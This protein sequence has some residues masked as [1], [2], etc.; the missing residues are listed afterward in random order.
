LKTPVIA[1][2]NWRCRRFN[3]WTSLGGTASRS[4]KPP[5][6][7]AKSVTSGLEP[8]FYSPRS[9]ESKTFTLLHRIK[10]GNM[11]SSSNEGIRF[12]GKVRLDLLTDRKNKSGWPAQFV[13][14]PIGAKI[15][16]AGVDSFCY[17]KQVLGKIDPN[18]PCPGLLKPPAI[19]PCS[20]G[21]IQNMILIAGRHQA[22]DILLSPR[23]RIPKGVKSRNMGLI[24][25]RS[26]S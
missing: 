1:S 17:A 16:N 4:A 5:L 11:I 12:F 24:V 7:L 13:A 14:C 22:Y 23:T 20:T 18:R 19:S 3:Q 2:L 10:N 8:L 6:G 9:Y 26:N 15:F 21:G 25:R